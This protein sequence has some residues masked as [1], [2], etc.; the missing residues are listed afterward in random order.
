MKER[1]YGSGHSRLMWAAQK[2]PGA[3][4]AKPEQMQG[5][6]GARARLAVL[7]GDMH[8]VNE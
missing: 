1:G 6:H 5:I 7:L 4:Y 2:T 3:I 8:Y